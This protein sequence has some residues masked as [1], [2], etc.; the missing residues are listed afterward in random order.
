[1]SAPPRLPIEPDAGRAETAAA[2][3]RQCP[4]CGTPYEPY[5]EYCLECGAR[6]PP[7]AGAPA[8]WRPGGPAD[9]WALPV[10]FAL[11][12]AVLATAVVLGVQAARNE[13]TV[14]RGMEAT[15]DVGSPPTTTETAP[16]ETTETQTTE[17]T[18]TTP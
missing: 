12:V 15:T 4:S 9:D 1:M 5:Q 8:P 16:A 3:E 17:T 6:L 11:V 18:S 14:F 7:A 10:L 2:E 13:T